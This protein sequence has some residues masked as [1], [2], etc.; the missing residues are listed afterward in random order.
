MGD[1]WH[2]YSWY[3]RNTH[4]KYEIYVIGTGILYNIIIYTP[5]QPKPLK[6]LNNDMF[7]SNIKFTGCA[8]AETGVNT[9]VI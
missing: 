9:F 4:K 8:T 5:I 1:L 6:R 3:S 7:S 2:I